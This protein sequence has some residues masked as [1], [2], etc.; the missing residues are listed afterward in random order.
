M[1]NFREIMN[2][3]WAE[4]FSLVN[5]MWILLIYQKIFG[6]RWIVLIYQTFSLECQNYQKVQF[7]SGEHVGEICCG[8]ENQRTSE[9]FLDTQRLLAI[10]ISFSCFWSKG[11]EE[12][13]VFHD[14]LAVHASAWPKNSCAAGY[15]FDVAPT[16]LSGTVE[17][18]S[19]SLFH[20]AVS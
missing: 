10:V 5:S 20:V 17:H 9:I 7:F 18:L 1:V 4:L 12:S 16:H 13:T 11:S 15:V 14:P 19:W 2:S 3:L 6:M 8:E